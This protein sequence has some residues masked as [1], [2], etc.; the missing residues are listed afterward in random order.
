MHTYPY[1]YTPAKI[2]VLL[3]LLIKALV[4]NIIPG[5]PIAEAT[6]GWH[7]ALR[8]NPALVE[9]TNF[10][11]LRLRACIVFPTGSVNFMATTAHYTAIKQRTWETQGEPGVE[12]FDVVSRAPTVLL[13]YV[14]GETC[15]ES[16]GDRS[17]KCAS[18]LHLATTQLQSGWRGPQSCTGF[19]CFKLQWILSFT[20]LPYRVSVTLNPIIDFF[21]CHFIQRGTVAFW[22]AQMWLQCSSSV[23]PVALSPAVKQRCCMCT[24][25]HWCAVLPC[26]PPLPRSALTSGYT[27]A[28]PLA[29]SQQPP[30]RAPFRASH[31]SA[32]SRAAFT[33]ARAWTA[34]ISL[35]PM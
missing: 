31:H 14:V 27:P 23:L 25:F 15:P 21:K 16:I 2:P 3:A 9:L 22:K 30:Q 33:E 32:A 24:Y 34:L 13:N 6:W 10:F 1:V 12:G 4:Y 5:Q 26:L 11:T 17:A 19:P 8:V 35:T 28:Q 29:P 20:Q 18:S 7:S